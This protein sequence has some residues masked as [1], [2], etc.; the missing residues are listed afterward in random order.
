MI[1]KIGRTQII[2]KVL[3]FILDIRVRFGTKKTV[4]LE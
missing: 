1:D 3:I 2:G 4:Q